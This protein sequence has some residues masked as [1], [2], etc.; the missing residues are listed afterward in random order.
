MQ[1]PPFAVVLL[2]SCFRIPAVLE[3]KIE[4]Y[5]TSQ[6]LKTLGERMKGYVSQS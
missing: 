4:K 3:N 5:F 2:L 1:Q 6:G